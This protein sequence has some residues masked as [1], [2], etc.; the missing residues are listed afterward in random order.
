MKITVNGQEMEWVGNTIDYGNVLALAK[1][2]EGASVTY[3]G[4]RHGD[5]QRSG[6]LH[7]TKGAIV[8]EDG[9]HFTAVR[10]NNA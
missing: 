5:A 6:I 1:Q 8:V 10:T 9:M 4:P 7:A 3:E 2:P